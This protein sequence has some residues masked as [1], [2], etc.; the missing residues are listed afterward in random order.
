[1]GSVQKGEVRLI[2]RDHGIGIPVAD[3][4]RVLRPFARLESADRKETEG[5]GLGLS[6]VVST[7]EAHGGRIELG[8]VA[9]GGTEATLVLPVLEEDVAME[10]EVVE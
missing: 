6:L 4:E 2:V 5:T 7:M 1:M 3:R 9:G 8:R 10:E